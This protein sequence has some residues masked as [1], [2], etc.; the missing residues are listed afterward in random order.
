MQKRG[1]VRRKSVLLRYVC[2]LLLTALIFGAS[3]PVNVYAESAGPGIS[4]KI[5][6][7]AMN[8]SSVTLYAGQ[9]KTLKV[10]GAGRTLKWSSSKK[11]VATVTQKGKVTAVG[12]GTATITA[13]AGAR[14]YTC[15]VLVYQAASGSS[16]VDKKIQSVIRKKI[17]AGMTDAEKVKAVHD[18]I[19]LNCAYDYSNYL[20][21]TIPYESYTAAGVLLKKKGVCQGYAEAFLLFMDALDIPCKMISGTANGGGHAWNLVKVDKKWYHIDVT[22]DDPVPDKEG[23]VRYSYF[24][25][26]DSVMDD[27]HSW[28][29]SDYPKCTSG[30]DKFIK[31]FGSVSKTTDAAGK[32]LAKQYRKGSRTLTLIAPQSAYRK[33][34]SFL[35]DAVRK[36]GESLGIS[37]GRYSYRMTGYGSYII[38]TVYLS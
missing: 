37:V 33:N 23:Y 34:S 12:K 20:N 4:G 5:Q 3:S 35:F 1:K 9:T 13:R 36:M 22:W 28:T 26:P 15:K 31:L 11:S 27:D 16:K 29:R 7:L 30:S 2:I 32:N 14:K 17:K 10:S 6:G 24:L 8:S 21:G 19:A 25:I 18:Y 38:F